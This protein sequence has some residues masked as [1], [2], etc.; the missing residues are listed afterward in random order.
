MAI[1]MFDVDFNMNSVVFTLTNGQTFIY[2][3]RKA[4]DNEKQTK[5]SKQSR[6]GKPAQEG[7]MQRI[8]PETISMD[9]ASINFGG[10]IAPIAQRTDASFIA[11]PSEFVD[12]QS[13]ADFPSTIDIA[14]STSKGLTSRP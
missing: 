8:D 7:S 11:G 3:L 9:D 14:H 13:Q 2:D 12:N 5:S 1:K 10:S 4:M 6:T